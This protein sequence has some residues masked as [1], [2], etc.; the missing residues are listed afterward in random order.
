[1]DSIKAR[2]NRAAREEVAIVPYNLAWRRRFLAEQQHLLRSL[3]KGIVRRIEHFGSTAV[4]GLAAK[5][6]IDIL[7]E[8]S[9]LR[10]ARTQIAPLLKAQ[11]YECFWRPTFGDNVR[12]WY[13]FFIKRNRRGIRTHHIHMITRHAAFGDHWRRLLFV[14][15]LIAHPKVARRYAQLKRKLAAAHRND[16]V[17]YTSG[18]TAFISGVLAKM[19]PCSGTKGN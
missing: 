2:V 5:P 17:A 13:A 14:D 11:G 12:P 6:I 9:S 15:Y 7:V 19:N 8:V 10:A 3:P 18:K 1:M 4:P 16:R